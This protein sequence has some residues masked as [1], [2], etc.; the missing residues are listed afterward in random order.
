MPSQRVVRG[1]ARK[2]L[3]L[4]AGE[5]ISPI[6]LR[7]AE[8]AV[9]AASGPSHSQRE[10]ITLEQTILGKLLKRTEGREANAE[11]DELLRMARDVT[12][13]LQRQRGGNAQRASMAPALSPPGN[14]PPRPH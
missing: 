9:L 11:D 13:A 2:L 5:L 4:V 14:P 1:R 6:E 12:A 3:G 7:L 10:N 8:L